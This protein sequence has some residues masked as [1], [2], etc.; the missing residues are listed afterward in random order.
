MSETAG[1][2]AKKNKRFGVKSELKRK[3]PF[4]TSSALAMNKK[5]VGRVEKENQYDMLGG[6]DSGGSPARRLGQPLRLAGATVSSAMKQVPK[7]ENGK[8]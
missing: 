3:Q 5:G 8:S 1:S 6:G 7:N 2:A 4:K